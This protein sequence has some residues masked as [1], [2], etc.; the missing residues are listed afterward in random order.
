MAIGAGVAI[1]STM[2]AMPPAIASITCI[3][4]LSGLTST[5]NGDGGGAY[6]SVAVVADAAGG[7]DS[8]MATAANNA[9]TEQPTDRITRTT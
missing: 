7:A 3:P 9:I 4:K 8:P 1:V 5:D 2:F 6:M